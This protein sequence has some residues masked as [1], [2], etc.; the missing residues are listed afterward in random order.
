M[1]LE[2]ITIRNTKPRE[3]WETDARLMQEAGINLVRMGFVPP[4]AL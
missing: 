2:L 3:R 1:D 4:V